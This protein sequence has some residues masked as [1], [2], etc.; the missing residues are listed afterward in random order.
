MAP[1][2]CRLSVLAILVG[3]ICL[4]LRATSAQQSAPVTDCSHAKTAVDRALCTTPE[5]R[6]ADARMAHAYLALKAGL[7]RAQQ[8]VLLA[9]QRR[10]IWER[11][12]RCADKSARDLIACLRAQTDQRRQFFAGEGP[13]LAVDAPLLRPAF[14]G[15]SRKGHYEINIVYPHIAQPRSPAERAFD[16]AVHEIVLDKDMLSASREMDQ[17]GPMPNSHDGTYELTYVDQRLASVVF[18]IETYG[19][20]A[21]HPNIRRQSLIFDFTS[22]RAL[23]LADV[24]RSPAEAVPAIAG[25]CKGELEARPQNQPWV[26]FPDYQIGATVE[27]FGNWAPDQA[28]VDILFDPG[29]IDG[30]AFGPQQCRL[31]W[32]DLSPWLKADGPLPPH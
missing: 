10:W 29:S 7:A 24:V 23:T 1:F 30:N 12:G 19:S 3:F 27:D 5:L 22:G 4:P 32:T 14:F 15:E 11:D 28:G 13:N 26:P 21:A 31:S 8:S 20:G 9:D 6:A 2:A 16:I 25:Q 18:T 17:G